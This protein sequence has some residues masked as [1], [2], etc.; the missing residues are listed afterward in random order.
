MGPKLRNLLGILLLLVS[1]TSVTVGGF[2]LALAIRRNVL[3]LF[4]HVPP[5]IYESRYICLLPLWLATL[6]INGGY[7]KRF[8][9]WDELKFIWK[10]IF[11]VAL[12]VFALAFAGKTGAN[13]S[14][15]FI[16]I[17]FT[18]LALV[19]PFT[20]PLSKRALYKIGLLKRKLVII[21]TGETA[22]SSLA[23]LRN[24]KNLGYE[25][26]GFIGERP[27]GRRLIDGVK[28]HGYLDRVERYIDRCGIHDVLIA[29][30]DL[31]KKGLSDLIGR[32]Q[33]KVENTLYLLDISGV[34]VLGTELRHF[35]DEE[36]LIIEVKNNLAR[37]LN[38]ITKRVFDLTLGLFLLAVLI[39]PILGISLAIRATSRGQAILRQKRIGRNGRIFTC[40]KFR[41]MHIDAEKHLKEL[42]ETDAETKQYWETYCKLEK[43]PRVTR[44]GRFLRETSLDEL[45]QLFNVLKG[46]MSLVGPRPYLP[47]E[48]NHLKQFKGTI[49]SVTPGITGFWQIS[50]RNRKTFSERL[51][52]DKKY[53]R[54]WNLWLDFVIL[55][56][57]VKVVATR[58]GAR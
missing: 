23:V 46:E 41:T 11:Y 38:H 45:P 8:T 13:L 52:L 57:T 16:F 3:P 25:V 10:S 21:G 19:F 43:D 40:Y 51:I 44:L 27:G 5:L 17:L 14:R 53:V 42:L 29:K 54:N 4:F 12:A 31:K 2:F 22:A 58:Q 24:E 28:V 35:F 18:V 56:K 26:A 37:P 47:R 48:R 20:R 55:F 9:F 32:I 36:N 1:D 7:S 49:L 30:P 33:M 6:A 39:I 15:T 50:G 34:A